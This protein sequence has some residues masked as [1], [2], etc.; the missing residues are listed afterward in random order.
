MTRREDDKMNR[1]PDHSQITI[2]PAGKIF[3]CTS[4]AALRLVTLMTHYRKP[5]DFTNNAILEAERI[6]NRWLKVAEPCLDGPP[7]EVS[8]AL[9]DDLNTP[10]AIAAMHAYRNKGEGKKL[11]AAMRFLGLFD[12]T[13]S[14]PDD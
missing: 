4:G 6:L 9:M 14:L 13:I 5:M 3:K 1:K 8:E 12:G 11:F 7:I 2:T 10:K